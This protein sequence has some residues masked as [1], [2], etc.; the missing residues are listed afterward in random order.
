MKE[1]CKESLEMINTLCV[2]CDDDTK[3]CEMCK[4]YKEAKRIDDSWKNFKRYEE[5]KLREY[6]TSIVELFEDLLE[7]HDITIPDEDRIGDKSEA[8]LYGITYGDLVDS[9]KSILVDFIREVK[10]N[11]FIELVRK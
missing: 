3:N 7:E 5:L 1:K 8:R 6:A 4:T 9:V 11:P 2:R 10:E